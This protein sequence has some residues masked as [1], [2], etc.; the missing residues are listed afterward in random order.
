MISMK[1]QIAA[2]SP[3]RW[4]RTIDRPRIRRV[5]YQLSY[6]R[7]AEGMG[8]EPMGHLSPPTFRAGTINRSDTPPKRRVK[9]S[10][11]PS[12]EGAFGLANQANTALATR[13]YGISAEVS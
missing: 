4:N 5:L 3:D 7:K 9:E 12:R 13:H 1:S 6:I 8:F 11:L 2:S 10:N